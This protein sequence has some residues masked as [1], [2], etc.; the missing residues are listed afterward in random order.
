MMEESFALSAR[1]IQGICGYV[2]DNFAAL[3]MLSSAGAYTRP[4]FSST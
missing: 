1:V 3:G 4:L 2:Q